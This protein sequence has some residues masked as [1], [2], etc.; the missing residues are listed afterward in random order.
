MPYRPKFENYAKVC[1]CLIVSVLFKYAQITKVLLP[2][3]AYQM[4]MRL[5]L[6]RNAPRA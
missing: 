3:V 4:A 6:N 2:A 5:R 1:I